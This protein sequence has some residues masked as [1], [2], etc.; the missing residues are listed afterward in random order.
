MI[1]WNK[2]TLL[3]IIFLTSLCTLPQAK[4]FDIT[5]FNAGGYLRN[6]T[7]ITKL[8]AYPDLYFQNAGVELQFKASSKFKL[9]G[10]VETNI[11]DKITYGHNYGTAKIETSTNN[12]DPALNIVN[13]TPTK[14]IECADGYDI[15]ISNVNPEL[16]INLKT[17]S[18]KIE[19]KET[20]NY[21]LGVEYSI[22]QQDNNEVSLGAMYRFSETELIETSCST[23]KTYDAHLL[24]LYSRATISNTPYGIKAAVEAGASVLGSLSRKDTAT[25][26]IEQA[27]YALISIMF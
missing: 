23:L 13:N 15:E 21:G 26:N 12:T 19:T 8:D 10:L 2:R 4:R 17:D 3:G 6:G 5:H 14:H 1:Y 9:R 7:L 25:V 11:G 24:F 16:T 20:L 22:A 27:Y 18:R